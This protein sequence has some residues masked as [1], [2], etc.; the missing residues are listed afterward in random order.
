[1]TNQSTPTL[2][3]HDLFDVARH[4][5]EHMVALLQQANSYRDTKAHDSGSDGGFV[6]D[7]QHGPDD[8][9]P[10]LRIGVRGERGSLEWFHGQE[11][12][13]PIGGLNNEWVDYWSPFGDH[14]SAPPG[15]EVPIEHV[16][17]A[18]AEFTR[19][20]QRPPHLTWRALPDE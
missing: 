17:T 9:G 6:W 1:M 19:S 11:N 2:L 20:G 16:Y 8:T 14:S 18:L 15:S 4:E 7:F 10:V 12:L 3:D 5:P 13:I